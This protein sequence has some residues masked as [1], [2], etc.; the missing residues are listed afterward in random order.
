M[1]NT[2]TCPDC[3][4]VVRVTCGG[5]RSHLVYDIKDWQRRCKRGAVE[6]PAWCF[7]QRDG[8]SPKKEQVSSA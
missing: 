1:A 8:T 7:V 4:L 2:I 5:R 3:G 6:Q